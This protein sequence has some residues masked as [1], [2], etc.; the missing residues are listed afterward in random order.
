MDYIFK[1]EGCPSCFF[2]EKIVNQ[3]KENWTGCLKFDDVEFDS[4]TNK[5]F[6]IV[7]GKRVDD[8]PVSRVPAYYNGE[9]EELIV[10]A[11]N[12]IEGI[13]DASWYNKS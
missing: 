3:Y 12:V 9:T 1:S 11:D 7:D 13:R 6:T 4:E 5:L 10:G 8:S 2:I